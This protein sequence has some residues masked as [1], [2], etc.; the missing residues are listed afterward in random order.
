MNFD[1]VNIPR[2]LTKRWMWLGNIQYAGRSKY[3][4]EATVR[5]ICPNFWACPGGSKIHRR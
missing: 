4:S 2:F 1:K 3:L 5:I